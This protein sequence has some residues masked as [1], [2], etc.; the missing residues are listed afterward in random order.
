MM[1]DPETIDEIARI[2]ESA[3]LP[4]VAR[5]PVGDPG[6]P[7]F[8][9][10]TMETLVAIATDLFF[11]GPSSRPS[12][13]RSGSGSRNGVRPGFRRGSYDAGAHE[14]A[15]SSAPYH[16]E[17]LCSWFAPSEQLAPYRRYFARS[18]WRVNTQHEPPEPRLSWWR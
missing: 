13:G 11:P 6:W 7:A 12:G 5:K 2:L 4:V 18:G 1:S 17:G 15:D 9:L 10:G 16:F 8:D 14:V 3:G